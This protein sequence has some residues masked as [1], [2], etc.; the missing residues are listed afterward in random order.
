M[1]RLV[2][3]R[4]E[5]L[6]LGEV[7][8]ALDERAAGALTL[9]AGR[10]RDHDGGRGVQTLDYT[11]HPSAVTR[12]RRVMDE[13]AE[14]HPVLGL[15]AVHR[16]GHLGVGDLAVVVASVAAHRDAAFAATRDLVDSL[17]AEVPVW[18][19]QTFDDGDEEWV[20]AP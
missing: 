6:R 18:K 14:R 15:A 8:D 12:L 1:V 7:V 16:V 17:K 3:V 11:A 19:H 10:V 2:D 9:F 20:G 13:V 4:S 5:P